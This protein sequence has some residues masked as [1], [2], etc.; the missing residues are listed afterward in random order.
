MPSSQWSQQQTDD[1]TGGNRV[2]FVC[3][4]ALVL[5]FA[6][7]VWLALP[8]LAYWWAALCQSGAL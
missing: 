6:G 5:A 8:V 2:A 4:L 7:A 1:V 3:A